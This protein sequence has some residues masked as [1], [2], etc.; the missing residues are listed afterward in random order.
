MF[1]GMFLYI[2]GAPTVVFDFLKLEEAEFVYLFMPMVAGMM[3]GA[4][5]SG[6]LAH[7]WGA[8]RTVTLALTFMAIGTM[9][10]AAQALSLTPQ[11]ITTIVPLVFYTIGSGM[12]MPAMTVLSL[13]CFP[14]NRGAASAVQGFMQMM[15]NALIASLA[16]PLLSHRP[17]WLALGQVLLIFIALV[18]WRYLPSQSAGKNIAG[19]N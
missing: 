1:G 4:W 9:L 18:L 2:A 11:V 19:A 6:Q 16:V 14:K 15:S 17:D 10:N 8:E 7:R 3:L 5:V 12:A 13:D